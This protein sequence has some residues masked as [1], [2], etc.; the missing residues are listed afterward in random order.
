MTETSPYEAR[1]FRSFGSP[2]ACSPEIS[3]RCSF[4]DEME[5]LLLDAFPPF[6]VFG[7]SFILARAAIR[8]A[9]PLAVNVVQGREHPF[10]MLPRL[11]GY[12]L[13][14]RQHVGG[15]QSFLQRFPSVALYR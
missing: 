3:G 10:R 11:F 6:G 7:G 1:G 13:L 8:F 2:S 15:T 12:P 14:F 4:F 5:D 9:H